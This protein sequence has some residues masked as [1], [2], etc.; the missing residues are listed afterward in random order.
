MH[1]LSNMIQCRIFLMPDAKPVSLKIPF[2]ARTVGFPNML[3]KLGWIIW[4]MVLLF[5]RN[6]FYGSNF[7]LSR[8]NYPESNK[9]SIGIVIGLSLFF[10]VFI[11]KAASPNHYLHLTG[12]P[13]PLH[14]GR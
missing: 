7:L 2:N 4:R 12:V 5:G 3:S 6:N 11:Y 13:L 1:E 8:K 9:M 14:T 10:R